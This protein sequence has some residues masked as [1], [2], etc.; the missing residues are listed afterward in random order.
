MIIVV[1]AIVILGNL[2]PLNSNITD[3]EVFNDFCM[4]AK[5]SG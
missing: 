4:R 3:Q 5:S 2:K 1:F